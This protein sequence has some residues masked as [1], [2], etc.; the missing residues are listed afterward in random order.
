MFLLLEKGSVR[1]IFVFWASF[2]DKQVVQLRYCPPGLPNFEFHYFFMRKLWFVYL[3][4]AVAVFPGGFGTFDELME[5]L[6]LLQ[7][8]KV[9]KS[10]PMVIYGKEYWDEVVNFDAMVKWG[11]IGRE[12]LDLFT[13]VDTPAEAFEY[14]KGELERFYL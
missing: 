6:T 7:T 14:L 8:R 2:A 1:G 13:F 4:K 12:D 9:E 10:V 3:A 5:V 11:V